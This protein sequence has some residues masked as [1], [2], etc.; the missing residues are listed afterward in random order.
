M[1]TPHVLVV[2]NE[3]AVRQL[4]ADSLAQDSVRVS[5]ATSGE[6][7]LSL[8][9]RARVH[10]L[11]AGPDRLGMGDELVRQAA[12]IQPLLGV[13]LIVDALS[14]NH[15]PHRTRLGQ[16]EQLPEPVTGDSLRSAIQR[17]LEP[18]MRRG[19]APKAREETAPVFGDD[20][21][22]AAVATGRIIA[23]S[24][25]MRE[26]LELVRISAPTD[27]SV[28]ICGEPDTGKEL[29]AREIHRQ[30]RRAAGPF[31]RVACGAL[32]ESEL[33]ERLFGHR[34][35]G[36][37]HGGPTPVTLLQTAQGGTL[38]L[39]NVSQLPLWGQ[40][41]LL[42]VLQQ[43]GCFR[44]GSSEGAAVDVRVIGSTAADLHAATARRVFSS[45]L[46]Y[47][48]NVVEIHVPPLRHRPQD[49]RPLAEAYLAMANSMGP[50]PGGKA[51]CRFSE[52]A[53]Q[54]LL[55]YDWPGN[56]LQLASVVA[57]AALVSEDGEIGR[58]EIAEALGSITPRG[59]SDT[60][61]VPLAGG[62]KEMERSIIETVIERCRGNKAAAA[63]VLRLH[64]RTLYRILQEEASPK[65]DAVTPPFTLAPT[66]DDCHGHDLPLLPLKPSQEKQEQER[67]AA[68]SP[69]L[70]H[71]LGSVP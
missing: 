21:G 37:D 22:E 27:V 61:S 1:E 4:V 55:E 69:S 53:L 47:Y 29:I 58:T 45:R 11:V 57:R 54:C 3:P 6:E 46:Y 28:L 5:F 10:V 44:A 36:S 8:L 68:I 2:H 23:A 39:E 66:V 31:V 18:Q 24:K 62:L 40:L 71:G 70:V 32:R 30:S 48:L 13:V 20:C 26:I 15:A 50:R 34:E 38:F 25:A 35:R 51:P 65:N 19:R 64:R 17:A 33:A 56:T 16:I 60:V 43:G 12:S 63:R 9:E 52:D 7:A 67:S 14:V 41:K 42:D 49:I 59:D